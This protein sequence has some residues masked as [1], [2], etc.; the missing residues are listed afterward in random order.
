MSK[1]SFILFFI[2]T[3]SSCVPQ[4]KPILPSSPPEVLGQNTIATTSSETKITDSP[5]NE[6]NTITPEPEAF[7]YSTIQEA[8]DKFIPLECVIN[9]KH[10]Q[11][12]TI[13]LKGNQFLITQ[14]FDNIINRA[15]LKD[16]HIWIWNESDNLGLRINLDKLHPNL[17]FTIKDQNIRSAKDL[18]I[19]LESNQKL[20]HP[21]SISDTSFIPPTQIQFINN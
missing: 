3:L 17:N 4:K 11:S 7:S 13:D 12:T 16:N 6:Q 5:T 8:I 1:Y 9:D 14:N 10:D 21:Q 18:I 20:C 2:L 15:V 19:V